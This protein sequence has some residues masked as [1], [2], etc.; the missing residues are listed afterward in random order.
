MKLDVNDRGRKIYLH[1]FMWYYTNKIDVDEFCLRLRRLDKIINPQSK[2]YQGNIDT[3][4]TESV[5][6]R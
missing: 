3:L 5:I 2:Y 1:Y 6:M 4:A